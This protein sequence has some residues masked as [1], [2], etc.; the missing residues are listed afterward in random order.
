MIRRLRKFILI[1]GTLLSVLIAAAFVAS[2]WWAFNLRF[3]NALLH[4]ASGRLSVFFD[5]PPVA[6]T[7]SS[8]ILLFDIFA[9]N[10]TL[11]VER[12]WQGLSAWNF[13]SFRQSLWLRFPLYAAFLAVAI[14]T[15]LVWRF[16]PKP[17]QPGHCRCG[18]D[19]QGNESGVCPEC[20]V[21]VQA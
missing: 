10:H 20:G 3:G 19:L 17:I 8:E 1:T 4:S 9:R 11:R 21:E 5:N 6:G 14:P 15:L 2:G 7:L 13:W 18:Y 16:G 12:H